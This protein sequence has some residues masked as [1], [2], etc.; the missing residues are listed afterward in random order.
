MVNFV[1][2]VPGTNLNNDGLTQLF[3]C[4]PQGGMRRS[5]RTNTLVIVSN[6]VASIYDDRWIDDV[7]HYTGMGQVDNQSLEFNQNR[8]LNES[9]ANGVAV[10]LFEVFAAKT[11]T[12]IGEV[13]LAGEPYQERQ[14]DVKG[15]ERFVWVFPLRLKSGVLPAIPDITLQQLNQVKEKQ[16]RKLSDAEVEA[17]ARRQGRDNVG[18][19]SAKVTQHQRSLW[20]AE[21]AKRRSKGVCELCQEP[22]PFV[23]KDGT[24]FLETHHIVWLIKGGADTVENTAALCP[25]CHRKMHVLDDQADRKLLNKRLSG[26]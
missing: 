1:L 22:A 11:Y 20:V 21:H 26:H 23:K 10:H 7:L 12:Y 16:A 25:N 15:H 5:N 24:P 9:R 8:T 13:M 14:A 6:H 3:Q 19:R 17:L 4:S 2:P 18:K